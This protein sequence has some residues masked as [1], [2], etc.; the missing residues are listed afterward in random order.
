MLAT[1]TIVDIATDG[2][3]YW[4]DATFGIFFQA[5]LAFAAIALGLLMAIVAIALWAPGY[6]FHRPGSRK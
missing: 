6:I 5:N 4:W 2:A 3:Q 1:S